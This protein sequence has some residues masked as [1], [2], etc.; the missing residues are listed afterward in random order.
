MC[1]VDVLES[2]VKF[3][4]FVSHKYSVN[5]SGNTS[6]HIEGVF[7]ALDVT[8]RSC[9][10]AGSAA[11]QLA[12]GAGGTDAAER[13]RRAGGPQHTAG[14]SRHDDAQVQERPRSAGRERRGQTPAASRPVD[15]TAIWR[16]APTS[17]AADAAF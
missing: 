5:I 9:L 13:R 7:L 10:C 8:E 17:A 15:A 3:L 2:F 14:H 11:A 4:Y 16:V 12:A 6:A 1:T